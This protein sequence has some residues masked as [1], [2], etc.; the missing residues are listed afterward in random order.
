MS[1]AIEFLNLVAPIAAIETNYPGGWV[2]FCKDKGMSSSEPDVAVTDGELLRIGGMDRSALILAEGDMT[3]MGLKGLTG[4]AS[5]GH[6]KDYCIFSDLESVK[7]TCN[8][9]VAG[10]VPGTVGLVPKGI[11]RYQWSR[12]NNLQKGSFGEHFAKMEFAMFGFLVFS[13][14]VDD[15][16]IDFVARTL[17]GD[18][19]DVQV[20]TITGFNYTFVKESKFSEKLLICLIVLVEGKPPQSFL[21]CGSDWGKEASSG[22]LAKNTYPSSKEPEYGIHCAAKRQPQLDNYRFEAVVGKYR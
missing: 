22:L 9:L 13:S 5:G 11:S 15:R 7:D 3:D 20:K 4:S 10:D 16:G 18:H 12:L 2:Q 6:W 14:E 1:I 21:F 8:W 19:H 17:N